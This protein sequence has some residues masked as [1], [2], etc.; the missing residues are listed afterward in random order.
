MALLDLNAVEAAPLL[1][2]MFH[3]KAVNQDM[4]GD[5]GDVRRE[6]ALDREEGDPPERRPGESV[7]H[8]DSPIGKLARRLNLEEK[9]ESTQA[10]S[11]DPHAAAPEKRS[12]KWH[13]KQAKK[14]KQQTRRC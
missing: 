8:P 13:R 2:R 10:P 14:H 6:L 9:W 12:A 11:A 5:W 1:R 3:A 4:V 7:H